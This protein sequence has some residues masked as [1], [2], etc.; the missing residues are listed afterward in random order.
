M[1][2]QSHNEWDPLK[3]IILG[4]VQKARFPKYDDVFNG[5]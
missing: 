5:C 1:N 2:I 3:S 4:D